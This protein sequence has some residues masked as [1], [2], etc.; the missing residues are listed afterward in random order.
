VTS[1]VS[2]F[3][4][5][6]SSHLETWTRATNPVD[7]IL[8]KLNNST[9]NRVANYRAQRSEE[10]T[11]SFF[12]RRWWL[13]DKFSWSVTADRWIGGFYSSTAKEATVWSKRTTFISECRQY[14]NFPFPAQ[15]MEEHRLLSLVVTAICNFRPAKSDAALNQSKRHHGRRQIEMFQV[16]QTIIQVKWHRFI[17]RL[18]HLDSSTFRSHW[19]C[20]GKRTPVRTGNWTQWNLSLPQ[21]KPWK[22]YFRANLFAIRFNSLLIRR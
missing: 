12:G 15:W 17:R 5:T 4:S 22:F 16:K 21:W 19:R 11:V 2:L 6:T 13:H 14:D 10:R 9:L 3:S 8:S 18:F 1:V 7:L 20:K